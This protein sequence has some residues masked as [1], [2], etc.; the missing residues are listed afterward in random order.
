MSSGTDDSP[1]RAGVGA[2]LEGAH[3]HVRIGNDRQSFLARHHGTASAL[4]RLPA[5][6]VLSNHFFTFLDS[7][8]RAPSRRRGVLEEFLVGELPN[9][10]AQYFLGQRFGPLLA[11]LGNCH[12]IVPEFFAYLKFRHFFFPLST[13]QQ[14]LDPVALD[15]GHP[16]EQIRV[17]QD[18]SPSNRL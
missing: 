12:E 9:K 10:V 7:E 18:H 5:T 6:A 1:I 17:E 14:S 16:R 3:E 15:G 13:S 11:F 8:G 4:T 2:C